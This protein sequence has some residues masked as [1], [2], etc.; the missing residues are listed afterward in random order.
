MKQVPTQQKETHL[1]REYHL[2]FQHRGGDVLPTINRPKTKWTDVTCFRE[3]ATHPSCFPL[4]KVGWI[5]VYTLF[6][7]F[8][9]V[10]FGKVTKSLKTW[11][12]FCQFNHHLYEAGLEKIQNSSKCDQFYGMVTPLL[13]S[14]EVY[15]HIHVFFF[16]ENQVP[17]IYMIGEQGWYRKHLENHS[18]LEY[19]SYVK[20][21]FERVGRRKQLWNRWSTCF[22]KEN[23]F[24]FRR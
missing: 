4:W 2:K 10:A 20:N 18:F 5:M 9:A 12:S 1:L 6:S 21:V 13:K 3:V 24:I 8:D 11:I 19:V 17:L 14:S 23:N 15:K 16:S 22:S 7:I